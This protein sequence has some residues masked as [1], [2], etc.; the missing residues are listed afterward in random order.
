MGELGAAFGLTSYHLTSPTASPSPPPTDPYRPPT[1][2]ASPWPRS[3]FEELGFEVLALDQ[4][5]TDMARAYGQ[6]M[7]W[8]ES[9]DLDSSLF[10]TLTVLRRPAE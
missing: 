6:A 4:D 9:M 8:A 5:E 1:D 10:A 3:T 7:G 2:I